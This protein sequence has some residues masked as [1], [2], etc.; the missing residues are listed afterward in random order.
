MAHRMD[1]LLARHV[2]WMILPLPPLCCRSLGAA[3]TAVRRVQHRF[4]FGGVALRVCFLS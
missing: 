2:A 1:Y 4:V 3:A